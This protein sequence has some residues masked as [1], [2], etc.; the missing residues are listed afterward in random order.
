MLEQKFKKIKIKNQE[1]EKYRILYNISSFMF[2]KNKFI[3]SYLFGFS[4][5]SFAIC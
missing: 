5:T 3:N 2:L 4:Y 1:N